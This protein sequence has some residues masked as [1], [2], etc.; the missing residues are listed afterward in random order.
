MDKSVGKQNYVKAEVTVISFTSTDIV[1]TS[2]DDIEGNLSDD[3]W[4]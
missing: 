3:T 4:H 2:N 1:T